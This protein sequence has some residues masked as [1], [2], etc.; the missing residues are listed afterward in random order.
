MAQKDPNR[1]EYNPLT[2]RAGEIKKMAKSYRMPTYIKAQ[3]LNDDLGLPEDEA[4]RN[5]K[6]HTLNQGDTK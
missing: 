5:S 2:G 4:L 6:K 1:Q 3:Y